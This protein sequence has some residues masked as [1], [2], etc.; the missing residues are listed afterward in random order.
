MRR[1][2][3]AP[4][5][6]VLFD[7]FS[8]LLNSQ[9]AYDEVAGSASLGR[10]WRSVRSRLSYSAGDYRDHDDLVAEAAKRIGLSP[11]RAPALVA[12][13]GQLRPWPE[14]PAVLAQLRATV[15]PGVVTNCSDELGRRAAAQ[16]G[17]PFDVVVTA[18]R[19]GAYKP[20][21]KPYRLALEALDV[22]AARM[23][24]VAG[25]PDDIA[26]ANR[27]GMPVYWHNRRGV[28]LGGRAR[29][30]L[31]HDSL[32]PLLHA[33][34]SSRLQSQALAFVKVAVMTARGKDEFLNLSRVV[35]AEQQAGEAIGFS[36]S[37]STTMASRSGGRWR[38][39]Q[40]RCPPR[41]RRPDSTPRG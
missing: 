3:T 37:R 27:V 24:F 2:Q 8:G 11:D 14:A 32:A 40:N 6:G 38:S 21:P 12:R 20:R 25:S 33:L 30:L 4:C 13:L 31:E 10:R 26:G 9:P 41:P 18:E 16:V 34:R 5:D 1:L 17:V 22:N 28:D 23:L 7:L 19:A 29:P 36:P 15:K 35:V 39:A